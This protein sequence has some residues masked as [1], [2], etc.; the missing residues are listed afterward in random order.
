[1]TML[2]F[3]DVQSCEAALEYLTSEPDIPLMVRRCSKR[4][5][6]SQF[7]SQQPDLSNADESKSSASSDGGDKLMTVIV[8]LKSEITA[9]RVE[10]ERLKQLLESGGGQADRLSVLE[11]NMGKILTALKI[12]PDAVESGR[13]EKNNNGA[14]SEPALASN[15]VASVAK[16][17][18][19][20]FGKNGT[21]A[22]G[23]NNMEENKVDES[24]EEKDY[25][26]S[27]VV[28]CLLILRELKAKMLL[29]EYQ[30]SVQACVDEIVNAVEPEDKSEI[31]SDDQQQILACLEGGDLSSQKKAWNSV[32][33]MIKFL[34]NWV[35]SRDE[36]K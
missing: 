13:A 28:G 30:K 25:L 6:S 5:T 8:E 24:E 3:Y 17:A 29:G 10:N 20:R 35:M 32:K 34:D 2:T 14:Q 21:S 1:M 12:A 27:E 23:A 22:G 7:Q 36:A 4:Q 19:R 18:A 16:A 11:A 15:Q 9:L 33:G 26:E 31:D